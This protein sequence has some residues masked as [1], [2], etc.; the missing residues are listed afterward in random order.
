[1]I[2][3]TSGLSLL[4]TSKFPNRKKPQGGARQNAKQIQGNK[5]MDFWVYGIDKA[6]GRT[7]N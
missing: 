5:K 1:V 7:S 2:S 4:K 3:I 6:S